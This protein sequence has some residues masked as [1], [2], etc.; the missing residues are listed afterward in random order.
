MI[1]IDLSLTGTGLAHLG[2]DGKIVTRTLDPGKRLGR[3]RRDFI[4]D[5]LFKLHGDQFCIEGLAF[6]SNTPSAMERAAMW[7]RVVDDFERE[8]CRVIVCPPATL[9]KFVTGSGKGEKEMM[10]REVYRRWGV[11]ARNNNEADA[12]GLLQVGRAVIGDIEDLTVP[13]REVVVAIQK[14]KRAA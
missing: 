5:T 2:I 3:D 8:G 4:A 7:Y 14:Q 12:A 9:K 13:Q 1:G 6:G 11:E 10:I